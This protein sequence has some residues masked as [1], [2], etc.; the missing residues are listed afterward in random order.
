MSVVCRDHFCLPQDPSVPPLSKCTYLQ[1]RSFSLSKKRFPFYCALSSSSYPKSA[2]KW[3]KD[4]EKY[5][6]EGKEGKNAILSKPSLQAR[7]KEGSLILPPHVK[8]PEQRTCE[9]VRIWGT[10][11]RRIAPSALAAA[12]LSGPGSSSR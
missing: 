9:H 4:R 12:S 3:T 8:I 5:L 10:S 7:K 11:S 2:N 1:T 6:Q